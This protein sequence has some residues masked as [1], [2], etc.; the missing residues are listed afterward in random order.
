MMDRQGKPTKNGSAAGA[1]VYVC[2]PCRGC[3]PHSPG[4]TASNLRAAAAYCKA[5]MEAGRIPMAPHLYFSTFLDDDDPA[6]RA[7][8]LE[9]GAA[10]LR[11]CAELWVF[12]GEASCGMTAEIE[13]AGALRIPITWRRGD[14]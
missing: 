10:L 12:G 3:P 7:R 13:L 11:L 5:V 14:A 6:Q 1:L 2:S 4:K 9:M 8:G